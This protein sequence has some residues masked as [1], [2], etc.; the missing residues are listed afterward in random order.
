MSDLEDEVAAAL[1]STGAIA[2]DQ[3]RQWIRSARGFRELA[4]LSRLSEVAWDRIEPPLSVHDVAG[5]ASRY[6]L[7]C[8]SSSDASEDV[9]S[10]YE[11]AWELAGWFLHVLEMRSG[12][13]RLRPKQG[14]H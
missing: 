4:L 8:M 7:R 11:A 6:L 1:A 5:V 13:A 10:R 12:L 14:T 9:P 2:S 3:V